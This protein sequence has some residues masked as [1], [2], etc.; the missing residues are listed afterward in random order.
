MQSLNEKWYG[1][2]FVLY[3]IN[4]FV[5]IRGCGFVYKKTDGD[6]KE[7]ELVFRDLPLGQMKDITFAIQEIVG[8]DRPFT[9]YCS[10]ERYDWRLVPELPPPRFHGFAEWR[11]NVF[12]P[13][14]DERDDFVTGKDAVFEMDCAA[15]KGTTDNW[16]VGI[17]NVYLIRD[18]LKSL[19]IR[20]AWA[21][22]SGSGGFHTWT[23][24]E[25]LKRFYLET[26]N[27]QECKMSMAA[28]ADFVVKFVSNVVTTA[29]AVVGK[30][31]KLF[32][33]DIAIDMSPN[34]KRGQIRCPYS[35]HP[36]TGNVVYPFTKKE[37]DEFKPS[38]VATKFSVRHVLQ[39]VKLMNREM[40]NVI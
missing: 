35:L 31:K 19:G 39:N 14:Q 21:L 40:P 23:P 30:D 18:I 12:K 13:L 27:Y 11:E 24:W 29:G 16:D 8:M 15:H 38:D 7:R 32:L 36:K 2:S 22:F 33:K 20:T 6:G 1:R 26:E 10:T 37:L 34:Y 28:V 9:F 17:A 4:R 25:E 3:D 5:Y